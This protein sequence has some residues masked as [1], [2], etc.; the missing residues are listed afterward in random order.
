MN[1]STQ[2]IDRLYTK[3]AS[4]TL[5]QILKLPEYTRYAQFVHVHIHALLMTHI[6]M[7]FVHTL[8]TVQFKI[9]PQYNTIYQLLT[10][11]T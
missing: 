3:P 8:I 2:S 9:G 10:N 4:L 11:Y 5:K 6:H 1:C 7:H